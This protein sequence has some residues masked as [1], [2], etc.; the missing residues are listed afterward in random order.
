MHSLNAF[1]PTNANAERCMHLALNGGGANLETIKQSMH[2]I[3]WF[4]ESQTH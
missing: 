4:V 1:N 3:A 2:C